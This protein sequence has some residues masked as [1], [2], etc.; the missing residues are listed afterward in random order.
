MMEKEMY[1]KYN[2]LNDR[3]NELNVLQANIGKLVF[4]LNENKIE[5]NHCKLALL[6]QLN[7]M[8]RYRDAFQERITN[9]YY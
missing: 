4:Y 3:I 5:D 2:R 6:D 8:F 1:A 9:G 7:A